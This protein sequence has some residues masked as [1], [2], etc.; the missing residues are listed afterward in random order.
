MSLRDRYAD[1]LTTF[2]EQ[3]S[4]QIT[5]QVS[6]D[7]HGT[8]RSLDISEDEQGVWAEAVIDLHGDVVARWGSEVYKRRNLIILNEGGPLD[9][10]AFGADLFSTAV[11][12]DLDTSGRQPG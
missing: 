2:H 8:L 4:A 7:N 12:E 6:R 10:A 9:D 1:H 5:H 3:A 11:M